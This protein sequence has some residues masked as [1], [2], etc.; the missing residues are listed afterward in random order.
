MKI[1]QDQAA[2]VVEV[3]LDPGVGDHADPKE[4]TQL[5]E[6]HIRALERFSILEEHLAHTSPGFLFA[7]VVGVRTVDHVLRLGRLEATDLVR[8]LLLPF[9]ERLRLLL[10]DY[11]LLMDPRG[12]VTGAETGGGIGSVSR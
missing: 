12:L 7:P 8:H 5:V 4:R 10:H 6:G 11:L 3:A 1:Q 9:S 2:T